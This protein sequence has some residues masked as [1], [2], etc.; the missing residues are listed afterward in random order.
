MD[1]SIL[2]TGQCQ[3]DSCHSVRILLAGRL[4][5]RIANSAV[6]PTRLLQSELATLKVSLKKSGSSLFDEPLALFRD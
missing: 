6:F 4:N 2:P 5:N 1:L 3:A